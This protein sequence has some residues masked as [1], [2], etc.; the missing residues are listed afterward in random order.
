VFRSQIDNRARRRGDQAAVR[1]RGEQSPHNGCRM[2]FVTSR[3]T[4]LSDIVTLT[5]PD[6]T[7][8][9]ENFVRYINGLFVMRLRCVRR[10]GGSGTNEPRTTTTD[11]DDTAGAGEVILSLKGG[12][13]GPSCV[14]R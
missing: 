11:A 8:S 6:T 14:P 10:S 9:F 3:L 7:L 4:K 13:P 5:H 12:P 1:A 2:P